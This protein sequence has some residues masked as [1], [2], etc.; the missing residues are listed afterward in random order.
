MTATLTIVN[1]A[2]PLTEGA[3]TRWVAPA[4][5][6]AAALMWL[7]AI[8]V[9]V[10]FPLAQLP[11]YFANRYLVLD[12]TSLLFIVVINTVFLGICVYLYSRERNTPA[13]MQDIRSRSALMLLMMAVINI[14]SDGQP[15]G[16][17][18]GADRTQHLV[19]SALGGARRG[20][21]SACRGLALHAVFQHVAADRISGLHVPDAVGPCARGTRSASWSISWVL[22]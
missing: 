17:A 22:R 16:A 11:L 13:L 9:F 3:G 21:Q 20:G 14:G 19:R 7:A 6:G 12:A 15:P 18:V 1:K 4:L 8:G 2:S 10:R 5:V